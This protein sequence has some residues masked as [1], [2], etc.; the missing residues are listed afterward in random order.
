MRFRIVF[1]SDKELPKF[2]KST[3]AF[4]CFKNNLVRSNIL[5][6]F[7]NVNA[8]ED[9]FPCVEQYVVPF[10]NDGKVSFISFTE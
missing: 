7:D 6:Q 1:R 10:L 9:V 8:T 3:L 5:N 2:S 4:D